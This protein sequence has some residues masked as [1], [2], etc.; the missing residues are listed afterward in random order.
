MALRQLDDEDEHVRAW[1]VRLL[2]DDGKTPTPAVIAA[3]A[4]LASRSKPSGLVRLFLASTLQRLPVNA[5]R[6]PL[7]EALAARA[8]YADDPTSR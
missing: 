2:V 5:D 1:A 8:E 4:A 3:F 6:W 7:A